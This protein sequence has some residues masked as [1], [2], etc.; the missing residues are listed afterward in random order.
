M[1]EKHERVHLSAELSADLGVS[2]VKVPKRKKLTTHEKRLLNAKK[3]QAQQRSKKVKLLQEKREKAM[4]AKEKSLKRKQL[5]QSLQKSSLSATEM[6]LMQSSKQLG[7]EKTTKQKVCMALKR[8]RAGIELK[9]EEKELLFV[10]RDDHD[11]DV[12]DWCCG[13]ESTTGQTGRVTSKPMN[14]VRVSNRPKRRRRVVLDLQ[15]REEPDKPAKGSSSESSSDEEVMHDAVDHGFDDDVLAMI[16]SLEQMDEDDENEVDEQIEIER[17]F[18]DSDDEDVGNFPL[19]VPL[20]FAMRQDKVADGKTVKARIRQ[21]SFVVDVQRDPEIQAARALLPVCSEEQVI[22][23]T[24]NANGVC[25][26]CAET[27]SGKTTQV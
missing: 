26:I 8:Q 18:E 25:I 20:E 5:L 27:G 3:K 1:L 14:V 17:I 6:Q 7:M 10:R 16:N 22:M 13:D 23:E 2:L 9:P 24:I 4:K 12:D 11:E 15:Q 21:R 19:T